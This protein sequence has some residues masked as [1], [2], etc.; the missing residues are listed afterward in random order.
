MVRTEEYPEK[1][2]Y[3]YPQ[4]YH[5]DHRRWI[6]GLVRNQKQ[7]ETNLHNHPLHP[8]FKVCN[9]VKDKIHAAV[10]SNP[11]LTPT[12][13]SHGKG[14]S[15]IPSA[16]EMASSHLGKVA[17]EVVK[18][19]ESLG[20]RSKEWSPTEFE[21]EADKINENDFSI[22]DD[23]TENKTALQKIWKTIPGIHRF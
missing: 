1:S 15:F 8:A 9:F 7:H 4:S 5:D 19:K 2:I 3:I 20:I 11:I 22:S 14:T 16:V 12:D 17:R 18:A 23:T 6:G 10:T 21:K 13:V